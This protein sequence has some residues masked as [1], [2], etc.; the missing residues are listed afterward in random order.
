MT[1][2]EQDHE[3]NIVHQAGLPVKNKY[4]TVMGYKDPKYFATSFKKHY[5]MRPTEFID[6]MSMPNHVSK[7]LS[8][9]NS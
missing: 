9:S 4:Q 8:S 1:D 5:G 7:P 2:W 3:G 6:K